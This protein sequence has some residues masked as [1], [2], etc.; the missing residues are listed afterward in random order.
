MVAP[1]F[2]ALVRRFLDV[3]VIVFA[4]QPLADGGEIYQTAAQHHDSA[5][6]GQGPDDLVN[7]VNGHDFVVAAQRVVIPGC[8]KQL[9]HALRDGAA[10]DF[11]RC[12]HL[13]PGNVLGEQIQQLAA[14]D[15]AACAA[16]AAPGGPAV[17]GAGQDGKNQEEGE[18]NPARRFSS[19]LRPHQ[20]IP[21]EKGFARPPVVGREFL[22]DVADKRRPVAFIANYPRRNGIGVSEESSGDSAAGWNQRNPHLPNGGLSGSA[23][24]EEQAANGKE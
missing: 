7:V 14:A 19:S 21:L 15:A 24:S 3:G 16:A 9:R 22:A 12:H 23:S 11:V 8:F 10:G 20:F 18:Q 4:V 17:S 5:V 2:F 1:H 13:Y 6:R